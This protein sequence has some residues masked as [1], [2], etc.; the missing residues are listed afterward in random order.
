MSLMDPDSPFDDVLRRTNEPTAYLLAECLL[1]LREAQHTQDH[2][3]AA[4]IGRALD[5]WG[6]TKEELAV[7]ARLTG[8]QADES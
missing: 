1:M 6:I 8:A 5:R 7:R 2:Y 4:S 3:M